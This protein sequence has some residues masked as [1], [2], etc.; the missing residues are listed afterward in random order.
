MLED[1]Y[2]TFLNNARGLSNFKPG[3]KNECDDIQALADGYCEAE[4][5]SNNVLMG[6]YI[7]ALFIRYWYMI[8]YLYQQSKSLRL[9]Q[10][11]MVDILYDAFMK[12]FK[13]KKW[14]DPND[15]MS[16]DSHGAQKCIEKC[17]ESVRLTMYQQSNYDVRKINYITHSL[18]MVREVYGDSSEEFLVEDNHQ[19]NIDVRMI[20]LN[21]LKKGK[22]LQAI[23]VD[24]ICYQDCLFKNGSVSLSRM[25]SNLDSSYIKYFINTYNVNTAN[26][27]EII[28]LLQL[29]KK[30]LVYNM[31][32]ELL[33]LSSDEVIKDL[34]ALRCSESK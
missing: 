29:P 24:S 21:A 19:D 22:L 12:A 25:I 14:L 6:R 9:E 26:I 10:E 27:T 8:P 18:D 23:I 5:V 15:K 13:N 34:Y 3:T 20:I 16:K 1:S 4:R 31:K 7:S 30:K 32:K 2:R 17:I 28:K 33:N 11:E